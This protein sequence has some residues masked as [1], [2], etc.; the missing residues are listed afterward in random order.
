MT[1]ENAATPGQPGTRLNRRTK[2]AFIAAAVVSLIAIVAIAVLWFFAR[3]RPI[4]L[5]FN[6]LNDSYGVAVDG[7]GNLYVTDSGNNRVLKLDKTF[8][9]Q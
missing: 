4:V 8:A 5:P 9:A 2:I 6:G 1:V 7:T 3:H